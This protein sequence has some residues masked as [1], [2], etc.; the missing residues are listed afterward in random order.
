MSCHL[1]SIWHHNKGIYIHIQHL[2]ILDVW[3]PYLCTHRLG[4]GK[5]CHLAILHYFH[6]KFEGNYCSPNN[7][8][9]SVSVYMDLNASADI[10]LI[11]IIPFQYDIKSWHMWIIQFKSYHVIMYIWS[12]LHLR[13]C[14]PCVW[15]WQ[16]RTC[17]TCREWHRIPGHACGV[18]LSVYCWWEH[19][20]GLPNSRQ[21]VPNWDPHTHSWLLV[22]TENKYKTWKSEHEWNNFM[23]TCPFVLR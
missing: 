7:V 23:F 20:A 15:W 9:L 21:Q 14:H 3:L 19:K 4:L 10:I 12:D 13:H 16:E 8:L 18:T 2:Q 6:W 17:K 1:P 22:H 11:I 5:L